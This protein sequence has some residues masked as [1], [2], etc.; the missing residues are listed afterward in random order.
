MERPSPWVGR[1][2]A[3]KF[4]IER[5]LAQ[6][7]V[8]MVFAARSQHGE[9]VALKLLNAEFSRDPEVTSRFL[10]EGFAAS[11]VNHP[12]VVRV[13]E[14]GTTDEGIAYLVMELLK[15]ELLEDRRTRLGGRLPVEEVVDIAEQLLDVLAAAHRAGIVH[16]DIKPENVFLSGPHVK[17]LDFGMAHL[18][19]DL[20]QREQTRTGLVLGTPEYMPPEQAMGSRGQVDAQSDIWAVGA[21]LF[22]LASGAQ[23][24]DY[25]SIAQ[26]LLAAASKP[27]RSLAAVA[28]ETPTPLV[29]LVDTALAFEKRDRFKS[30]AAMLEALRAVRTSLGLGARARPATESRPELPPVSAPPRPRAPSAPMLYEAPDEP[31]D[32]MT[33]VTQGIAFD[34]TDPPPPFAPAGAP[35]PRPAPPP[36]AAPSARALPDA[37]RRSVPSLLDDDEFVPASGDAPTEL[38]SSP[39]LDALEREARRHGGADDVPTTLASM[40]A[41]GGSQQ[42]TAPL[43]APLEADTLAAVRGFVGSPRAPSALATAPTPY[44]GVPFG[45][46]PAGAPPVGGYGP[47][48]GAAAPPWAGHGRVPTPPGLYGPETPNRRSTLALYVVCAV[49]AAVLLAAFALAMMNSSG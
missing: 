36:R 33:V 24:H 32:G 23:V 47:P 26:L 49:T 2:V 39:D 21:T 17:V 38:R 25:E 12:G 30:A 45:V 34:A 28:P 29:A 44:A 27:A 11:T 15:G 13:F 7:G 1:V 6:G 14:N 35:L 16:R 19:Q 9:D 20:M 43:A 46:P 22:T 37:D 5:K 3:G 4:R 48:P 41:R 8:A 18:K 10:R 40:L 31:E 42:T